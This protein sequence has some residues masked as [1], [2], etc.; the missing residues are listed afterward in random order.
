MLHNVEIFTIILIF[1]LI[2][3]VDFHEI[4]CGC[5]VVSFVLIFDEMD[6]LGH[7]LACPVMKHRGIIRH[8]AVFL[9]VLPGSSLM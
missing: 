4:I 8:F 2:Q 1:L 6:F 7:V 3:T 9:A 5:G